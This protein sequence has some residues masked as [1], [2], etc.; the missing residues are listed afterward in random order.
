[1]YEQMA[2]ISRGMEILAGI[3][4]NSRIKKIPIEMTYIFYRLILGLNIAKKRIKKVE[5]IL[6]EISKLKVKDKQKDNIQ[7]I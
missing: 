3:K 5:N 6:I 1:M 2:G 4:G 7:K